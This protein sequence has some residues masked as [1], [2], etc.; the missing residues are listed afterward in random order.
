MHDTKLLH[1]HLPKTGGT[2]LWRFFVDC[3]GENAVTPPQQAIMLREALLQWRHTQVISGHFIAKHGD[4]IPTDRHA[5][6]VLRDPVD[7]FISDYFYHLLDVDNQLVDAGKRARNLDDHI[8]HLRCSADEASL[9][10][11]MLYPLGTSAQTR[12]STEEKLIAAKNAL[13][14]FAL[15]GMQSEMDDFCSMLCAKFRWPHA[16]ARPV[17]VT[18]R[19]LDREELSTSQRRAIEKLVEPEIELYAYA[20][21]RFRKDR[22]SFIVA[23]TGTPQELESTPALR[24]DTATQ[25]SVQNEF[26][27]LRCRIDRIEVMGRV[28]GPEQVMTGETMDVIFH[29]TSQESLDQV[30]VGIAIRDEQ[31]SLMFGTNSLL[32]GEAYSLTPGQYAVR[33]SMLNRL[34]PGIFHIDGALTPTC[35]H[36]D[37]CYHWRDAAA[38]FTVPTYAT[39]HFEGRVLMDV[40]LDIESA[41]NDAVWCRR[42]PVGQATAARTFGNTNKTLSDFRSSIDIMSSIDVALHESDI[43]LQVKVTNHG[44]ESW[45]S[46]GRYPTHLSYRWLSGD[47]TCLVP[48]GMRSELPGN[49]APGDSVVTYMHVRTPE[50]TGLLYLV[51]SLVQ[52]HVAWFVDKDNTNGRVLP[53]T[54]T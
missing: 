11:E 18:S 15:V 7:R 45:P 22:R 24:N 19:R 26:G 54:V 2:A 37:G 29:V 9:Q 34:G 36:Y 16:L 51:A 41:G 49:V 6:T 48:D 30:N 27:D 17:N 53:I 40:N 25:A 3:L 1:L 35:S 38:R 39:H 4:Q 5:V 47:G 12:L 44:T 14:H 10:M 52:E 32:L 33:F 23:S 8:E 46:S 20:Q 50:T 21:A 13:D 28:S 31:G 43:L 42:L